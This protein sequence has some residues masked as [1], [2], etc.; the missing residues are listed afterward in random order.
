MTEPAN[1]RVDDGETLLRRIPDLARADFFPVDLATG[2]K[3]LSSGAFTP[4]DDGI[5]VYRETLLSRAGLEVRAVVRHPLNAVASLPAS[6]VRGMQLDV[7]PD[8]Q[9]PTSADLDPRLGVAHALI[10]GFASLT[11]D[12]D[13]GGSVTLPRRRRS[14]SGPSSR[15]GSAY[16]SAS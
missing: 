8:P 7:V 9:P 12:S 13:G 11:K 16:R 6:V 3:R 14:L 15:S 1:D 10:V 2:E 5:S 4:D